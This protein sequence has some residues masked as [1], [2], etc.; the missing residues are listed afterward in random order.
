MGNTFGK[1]F[2]VTTFGESHGTG[3]G[4]VIDGV[5]GNLPL[6]LA[7]I[8][9]HLDRRRPGQ[10]NLTSPRDESDTVE[11]LSGVENGRT[12]GGPVTFFV[13]NKNTIAADYT[14]ISAVFR[15]GHADYTM[16]EKYGVTASSG[17]GRA[18]ARE[19][20]GRVAAGALAYQLIRALYKDFEVVAWV[21]SIKD[22]SISA[23]MDHIATKDLV[24]Q[25]QVRCPHPQ[26]A[27][28]MEAAILDAQSQGDSVGGIIRC[29]IRGVPSGLGEP[30][31]DKL[32]AELAKAM[33][34]LP[35][36]R[37]FEIG[38]GFASTRMSGSEHNDAI[39]RKD[40]KFSTRTN[41][42]GGIAGGI[43]NGE[44]ITFNV[45][46]K[47]VSTIFKT[48]DT[49]DRAGNEIKFK[50]KSGRHDPCVLP[51]AVPMVEAMVLMTVADHV[52]RKRATAPLIES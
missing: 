47:P 19:T 22:I 8:Q 40:G 27:K 12:L 7:I 14:D 4:A 3:V 1:I 36:S 13:R 30:V 5:P 41:H 21:H 34:S 42:A 10:S 17:G 33:L 44:M 2:R 39:F 37:G 18:S 50:L 15:P 25:N 35:A 31:F 51:R 26:T 52:L 38:S 45:A 46:F 11:C 24:D 48:Q 29:V 6:D 32:E 9:A 28:E 49:I 43:S 20:I 16:L 23:D